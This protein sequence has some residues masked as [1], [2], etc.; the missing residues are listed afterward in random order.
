ML[1]LSMLGAASPAVLGAL[2]GLGAERAAGASALVP[3]NAFP[4]CI[5]FSPVPSGKGWKG[6]KPPLSAGVREDTLRNL[7]EHGFSVLYYPVGGLSDT[8]GQE[9]LA[10]AEALGMKVNYMT[11]GFELFDRE[12]APAISVYS[13]RYAEEVSKRVEAGSG[14]DEDDPAAL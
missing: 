14:A 5:Q 7:I 8:E 3:D 6:E 1:R 11:G 9:V 2:V 12:H 13:P 10:A 4:A